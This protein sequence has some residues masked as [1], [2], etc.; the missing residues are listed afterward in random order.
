MTRSTRIT[1]TP[2]VLECLRILKKAVKSIPDASLKR[3]AQGAVAYLDRTFKGE[4]Q[5]AKGRA[6]PG[7]TRI[8]K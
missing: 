4:P 3:D 5:P 6:C 1:V 8:V 7:G 2:N